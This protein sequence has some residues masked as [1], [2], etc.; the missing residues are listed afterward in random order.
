MAGGMLGL[1][2][3]TLDNHEVFLLARRNIH[4][5]KVT[6]LSFINYHHP[7]QKCWRGINGIGHSRLTDQV[8]K[9]INEGIQTSG[10]EAAPEPLLHGL[11]LPC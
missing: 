10:K 9:L 2:I 6:I 3:V 7:S 8:R 11:Q 5:F 1:R 4:N